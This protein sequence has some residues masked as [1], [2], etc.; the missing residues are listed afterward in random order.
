[1]ISRRAR[2]RLVEQLKGQGISHPKVLKAILDTPRHLFVDEA[3]QSR[4]YENTALPIGHGQTISQPYIV[5]RM[6]Q[7]LLEGPGS[8]RKVLEIGTGSGYQTAILAKVFD[9]VYTVER[10]SAFRFPA[11]RRFNQLGLYNISMLYSD[12]H[13]GWPQHAPYDGIIV[14]AAANEIPSPLLEQLA[15]KGVMII[16]VAAESGDDLQ[17]L[18]KLIRHKDEFIHEELEYVRFVPLLEERD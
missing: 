13:E 16:P 11:K 6:T 10:I 2:E 14:T 8:P 15:E 18:V 9:E 5:A 1:M 4:A 3:L 17:V 7:A 12:G